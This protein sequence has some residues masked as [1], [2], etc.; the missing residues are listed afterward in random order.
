MF[1]LSENSVD[2]GIGVRRKRG[3]R[4]VY[5]N[6]NGVNIDGDNN[7]KK[8]VIDSSSGD[9]TKKDR[10]EGVN[11]SGIDKVGHV[12]L[13]NG[14]NDNN[15]ND[16]ETNNNGTNNDNERDQNSDDDNNDDDNEEDDDDDDDEEDEEEDDDDDSTTSSIATRS[17][18]RSNACKRCHALKVKCVPVDSKLINGP[19]T[20]CV[21]K[22]V[23]CEYKIVKKPKRK[24]PLTK[25]MKLKVTQDEI[26]HLREELR[27]RDEIIKVLKGFDNKD[28]NIKDLSLNEKLQIYSNEIKQLDNL[29]QESIK[30]LNSS[31]DISTTFSSQ[32]IKAAERR[33][34]LC[35]SQMPS[36]DILGNNLLTYSQ[37]CKLL[38]IFINEIYPRYPFIE[39]PHNLNINYLREHEPLLFVLIIYIALIADNR[40]EISIEVQ[41]QL[42][43]LIAKSISSEILLIGN[44]SLNILK[45][46]LLYI[47]WYSAPEL[48]HHR[49]Y[50]MFTSLCVS[51]VHDLGI[52]GRPYFFYNKDDGSV[53]KTLITNNDKEDNKS[54]EIK[55]IVLIVYIIY[56]AISFF[57]KRV[58]FLEWTEYLEECCIK[59]ENSNLRKYKLIVIYAKMN[60]L[61]EFIYNNI[62]KLSEQLTVLELSSNKYK[63]SLIDYLNQINLLKVKIINNFKENSSDYNL[64]MSYIYSVQAYI[65]EPAIQTLVKSKEIT[66]KE[67][68]EVFYSTLHQICESCILSLK[69]FNKLNINEMAVNPLFHTSRILYTSGMLLRI[70]YLSLTI[71]KNGKGKLFTDESLNIIK[72]LIKKIDETTIK[73]SKNHFI[74]KV[75]IVLGLFIHTCLNQWNLSYKSTINDINNANNNNANNNNFNNNNNNNN[76]E[77][78][79]T[80]SGNNIDN[81]GPTTTSFTYLNPQDKKGWI[82]SINNYFPS[83][84]MGGSPE[85]SSVSSPPTPILQIIHSPNT[86]T[87][88]TNNNSNINQ[89]NN[90]PTINTWFTNNTNNTSNNMPPPNNSTANI[91][92]PESDLAWEQ[93]YMAF[94]DEFWSDLFFDEEEPAI[95]PNLL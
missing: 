15:S 50:H 42:E 59:L 58:V 16:N 95:P 2:N 79:I 76:V 55:S 9:A 72:Q 68:N 74:K 77:N 37:C 23:N 86:N 8:A 35:E 38:S 6:S 30:T 65:Y 71:P 32:F 62:H 54:L 12:K 49:R 48:F 60:H 28:N 31:F 46:T 43:C 41:L 61:M 57:F 36:L 75:R 81:S 78:I 63:M 27:K 26:Q 14:S 66:T 70:R 21:K 89:T 69:H 24:Q 29:S 44:K 19:C 4:E 64:L 40:E 91:T 1:T 85:Y 51:M 83:T 93:Q 94:N 56:M 33:V 84:D 90:N 13:G 17:K 10:E 3:I 39:L 7:V 82:S 52:N 20:R 80:D 25:A 34:Q 47:L 88:N 18:R 73:F 22:K 87:N 11:R 53:K 67:Y 92:Q 5:Q 45:I